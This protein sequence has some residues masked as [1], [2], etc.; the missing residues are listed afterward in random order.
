MVNKLPVK[1][2][3][4]IVTAVWMLLVAGIWFF[5]HSMVHAGNAFTPV[6]LGLLWVSGNTWRTLLPVVAVAAAAGLLLAVKRIF[7][8]N[9]G[10]GRFRLS[11][12]RL[13]ALVLLAALLVLNI[14]GFFRAVPGGPPGS[15]ALAPGSFALANSYFVLHLLLLAG[16]AGFQ[17]LVIHAAGALSLRLFRPPVPG[18]LALFLFRCA[19]GAGVWSMLLFFLAAAGWY[20]RWTVLTA[21]GILLAA[22]WRESRDLLRDWREF[23]LEVEPARHWLTFSLSLLLLTMLALNLADLIRPVPV[24]WDDLTRYMNRSRL[25]A[26]EG[27]LIPGLHAFPVELINGTGFLFFPG[28]MLALVTAWSGGLLTLLAIFAFGRRHWSG[29]TGLIAATVFYTMP[30]VGH[31]SDFDLK[32]DMLPCFVSV[33]ALWAMLE[34]TGTAHSRNWLLLAATLAGIAWTMK[35]TA[36]FLLVALAVV[37]AANWRNQAQPVRQRLAALLLAGLLGALPFLPWAV[38]H[39]TSRDRLWPAEWEELVTSR[40][41]VTVEAEDW[42]RLGLDPAR[43][44]GTTWQEEVERY[45]GHRSD[46]WTRLRLPWDLTMNT[47][48]NQLHVV[49]GYLFLAFLPPLLLLR[50]GSGGKPQLRQLI[51]AG[52]VY[53]LAWLIWGRG[54]PWY[55][56]AGFVL[57]SLAVARFMEPANHPPWLYRLAGG[58]LI[59][60]V[61]S[62][63]M[64]QSDCC[65]P[66]PGVQYAA[67]QLTPEEYADL[68]LPGHR[69]AAALINQYPPDGSAAG[70]VMQA[71]TLL[72]YFITGSS[73]R[74][75]DDSY[76]DLFTFMDSEKN[77]ALTLH[78]LRQ[79]GIRFVLFG[80]GMIQIE[81]DPEGTLHQKARRFVEFANRNLMLRA[82]EKRLGLYVLEVPAP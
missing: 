23:R 7:P 1:R 66:P 50:T 55:G 41:P 15:Q 46:W 36:A 58:L 80:P 56:L 9:A 64:L 76:L 47:H 49:T 25:V 30:M 8:G 70:R 75:L 29:R 27:T 77:D 45:T 63:V 10:A 79:L 37:A 2:L 18:R 38:F 21:A 20:G 17:L 12:A 82:E 3:A 60:G 72:P 65:G 67:G 54:I 51:L 52:T 59:T 16:W 44:G 11:P 57:L 22:A 69:A 62:Q 13:T 24:G 78:R 34:W 28:A 68:L 26:A 53:W 32:T 5:H 48:V 81:P 40:R 33:M 4:H 19:A 43:S 71:G 74:L 42:R 31:L 14:S 73:R 39:L 6:Q 35:I 61:L